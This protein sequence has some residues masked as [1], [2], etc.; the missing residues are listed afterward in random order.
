MLDTFLY[1]VKIIIFAVAV[2]NMYLLGGDKG[3]MIN[4]SISLAL[5]EICL[6]LTAPAVAFPVEEPIRYLMESANT[7]DVSKLIRISVALTLLPVAIY[8]FVGKELKS[9]RHKQDRGDK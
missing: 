6:L 9:T 1:L 5:V 7:D 4:F 2:Y 3:Q 8:V